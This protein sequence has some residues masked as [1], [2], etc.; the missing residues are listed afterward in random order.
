M[1]AHRVAERG[2]G[3]ACVLRLQNSRVT[4][5]VSPVAYRGA[6]RDP[7]F[8][9]AHSTCVESNRQELGNFCVD[10]DILSSDSTAG[11]HYGERFGRRSRNA[12]ESS[13]QTTC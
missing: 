8:G 4:A 7:G 2:E 11:V 9:A 12:V 13:G 10:L 6:R 5:A 3:L 1:P